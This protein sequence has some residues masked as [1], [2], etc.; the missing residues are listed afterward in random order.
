[1]LRLVVT[2][3]VVFGVFELLA[4]ARGER[5]TNSRFVKKAERLARLA[6]ALTL[7]SDDPTVFGSELA[8]F[9]DDPTVFGSELALFSAALTMFS[10]LLGAEPAMFSALLGA[11]EALFFPST[12]LFSVRQWPREV[13]TTWDANE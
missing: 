10:A 13:V 5:A 1:M 4:E 12:L 3:L 9:S 8:L 11:D 7:F 2:T 6:A